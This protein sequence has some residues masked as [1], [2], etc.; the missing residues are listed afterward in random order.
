MILYQIIYNRFPFDARNELEIYKSAIENAFEFPTSDSFTEEFIDIVK[1]L[2]EKDVE[3]RYKSALA[4]IKDLGFSLDVS[5]TKEF[6]PAKVYSCR[7]EVIN[8][9]T[10]YF[11]DKSSSEVYTI[12][13]FDG[14]GKTSLLQKIQEQ[15]SD[16]VM[17]SD[18]KGKYCRR[19]NSLST[20]TNNLFTACLSESFERGKTISSKIAE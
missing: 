7:D 12:K 16:A 4:I 6:L 17:I 10:K 14:V 9:L 20:Q 1:K 11:S 13:G 5:I 2:L 3:K 19:I 8:M 15:N 18:V